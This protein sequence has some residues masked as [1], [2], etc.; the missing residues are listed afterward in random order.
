[1]GDSTLWRERGLLER[2]KE[3]GELVVFPDGMKRE[4][5]RRVGRGEG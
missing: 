5:G 2:N 3:R 4:K 1:M